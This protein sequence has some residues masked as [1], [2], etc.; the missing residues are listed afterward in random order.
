MSDP[1]VPIPRRRRGL[2]ILLVLGALLALGVL[3]GPPIAASLLK[4]RVADELSKALGR[5]VS[6]KELDLSLLGGLGI[7]LE[8]LEAEELGSVAR[9][10]LK[11]GIL[12]LLGGKASSVWIRGGTTTTATTSL[13]H[14]G[15]PADLRASGLDL[16]P[17]LDRWPSS[18][19]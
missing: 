12:P 3:A 16:K 1:E 6:L 8:G 13:R 2:K 7:G 10:D 11:K 17:D 19:T 9:L 18:R 5:R 15:D 4:D 14:R